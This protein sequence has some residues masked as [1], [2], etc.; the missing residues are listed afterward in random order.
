M[1]N[2]R[3]LLVT[4]SEEEMVNFDSKSKPPFKDTI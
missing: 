3:R 1:C 4:T 2:Y